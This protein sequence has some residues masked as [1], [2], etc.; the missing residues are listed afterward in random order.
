MKLKIKY[1]I[2]TIFCFVIQSCTKDCKDV[3]FTENDKTWFSNYNIG[4]K[5]IFKS[6]LNDLDTIIITNKVV[7]KPKG[8]CIT[9]ASGGFDKEFARIDYQIKKDSLNLIEDY[10]IQIN[11]NEK[12]KDASPVIR[13]LNLEYSSFNNNLP[14][15]KQSRLNSDWKNIYTFNK[16]NCPYSNLNGK[17]GLTEFEWD[18]KHGLVS[19]E[20]NKGEKWILIKKQ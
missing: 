17:F 7:K 3:Y 10:F 4:D 8:N 19:Y 20:N 13:L 11:A 1:L 16:E 15:T 14:K 5:L 9:F 2:L 18:K 6:Q 12:M